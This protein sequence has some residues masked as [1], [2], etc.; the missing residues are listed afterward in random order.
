M[1]KALYLLF[2]SALSPFLFGQTAEI[3]GEIKI[4]GTQQAVSDVYVFLEGTAF[5]DITNAKGAFSISGIPSGK[6]ILKTSSIGL[7]ESTLSFE[8]VSEEKKYFS[9]TVSEAINDL[10]VVLINAQNGTGGYMGA[11]NLPGSAHY[12]SKRDIA[13]LNSGNIHDILQNIPGVQLQEEDGF[14]LR[15]NIGLRGTGSERSSKITVMEDGVLSAP[16]PYAAPA[17]YYFP[18]VARMDAI[19]IMKG[20]S[21]I[22]YGPYTSGGVINLISTAIP[23][24]FSGNLNMGIGSF[25]HRLIRANVGDQWKGF[26]FL[27]EG[28]QQSNDG[29]KTINN[30]DNNTGF[31]KKDWL[32]KVKWQSSEESRIF[33]SVQ[34]KV[35]QTKE[36]SNETYLGISRFDFNIDP[37][38]RYSGSQ[39]DQMNTNHRQA[40]IQYLISPVK[41]FY[42][43]TTAYQNNFFRNWY[44]LD[45]VTNREGNA[46]SIANLLAEPAAFGQEYDLINGRSSEANELLY[47][48]ANNRNYI[49]RGIQTKLNYIKDNNIFEVG[50]R[51]HY[52]EMDRFQWEDQYM[53]NDNIMELSNPGLRGAES[54]RIESA[55]AYA[56]YAKYQFEW[57]KLSVDLGIRNEQI[58]LYR[59][60]FG[61]NDPERAGL[62]LNERTNNVGI[63]IPGI[64]LKYDLK[65]NQQLFGG[66]HRGF[67][68]PG[69]TPGSEPEK[70]VNYE[71]GYR[72]E[73]NNLYSSVVLYRNNYSNLLG[74]DFASSGGTGTGETFNGGESVAQGIEYSL[75]YRQPIGSSVYIPIQA[76]YTFTDATFQS[77]FESSFDP[78]G[79]VTEGDQLPYLSRNSFNIRTGINIKKAQ[80]TFS[81]NYLGAMRTVAGQGAISDN[82]LINSRWLFNFDTNYHFNRR[83]SI[84]FSI[85]NLLNKEYIVANRPAG[86]RPG[87]P[88]NFIFTL[89]N[90]F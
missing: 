63:W 48:K 21:Q 18:T 24:R 37:Y 14:G 43:Q 66:V 38:Q 68:P 23:D 12:L 45:K 2:F 50:F 84:Q 26:S 80:A 15:P 85:H 86:W 1:T 89:S 13:A 67:S 17:A 64:A 87:A 56:S 35:A 34:I 51:I 74:S 82:E 25:G 31:D 6:Y 69:S 10:P 28:L 40:N 78:W 44:K 81:A 9:L 60:D 83:T 32:A 22:K 29:F 76:Q 77:A 11:M 8:L 65:S 7:K 88:R 90:R 36:L 49:S 47:V 39:M 5:Y 62:N 30:L 72:I 73:N 27:V 75:S 54:N 70:S 33:Q 20:A 16:A 41:N 52:D 3:A 61:R 4:N 79:E 19:E 46:V 57:N 55:L 59:G 71:L 53:M 42:I 58:G